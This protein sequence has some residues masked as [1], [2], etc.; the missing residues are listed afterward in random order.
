L[1]FQITDPPARRHFHDGSHCSNR[2][3]TLRKEIAGSLCS[4]RLHARPKEITGSLC[5]RFRCQGYSDLPRSHKDKSCGP[6][7]HSV[8][9]SLL[10]M[11]KD[12]RFPIL[13]SLCPHQGH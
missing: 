5:L 9:K 12:T 4:N 3:Q 1:T 10:S 7:I 13:L 11:T 2:H 6:L 8:R